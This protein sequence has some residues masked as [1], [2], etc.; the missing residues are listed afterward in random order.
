[1]VQ[2]ARQR[3]AQPEA[4]VATLSYP[5]LHLRAAVAVVALHHQPEVQAVGVGQASL[6]LLELLTKVMRAVRNQLA[7]ITLVLVEEVRVRLVLLAGQQL[8]AALVGTVWLHQ[9]RVHL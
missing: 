9:S 4:K 1:M 3:Q 8:I 5:Q 2:V 7:R 6:V